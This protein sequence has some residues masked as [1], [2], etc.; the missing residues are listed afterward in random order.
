MYCFFIC[1]YNT[2]TFSQ[3]VTSKLSI[4]HKL[5]GLQLIT[6]MYIYVDKSH[7][8][9][10]VVPSPAVPLDHLCPQRPRCLKPLHGPWEDKHKLAFKQTS[11]ASDERRLQLILSFDNQPKGSGSRL[12]T[13]QHSIFVI[14]RKIKRIIYVCWIPYLLKILWTVW[15]NISVFRIIIGN[16]IQ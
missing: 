10:F 6:V 8:C 5:K 11:P 4:I 3:R 12:K 2:F 9:L 1:C 14:I 15:R 13:G 7:V 16:E